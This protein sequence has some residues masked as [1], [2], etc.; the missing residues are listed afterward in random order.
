MTASAA[1]AIPPTVARLQPLGD[2]DRQWL[3]QLVHRECGIVTAPDKSYLLQSRLAAVAASLAVP[4]ITDLLATLRTEQHI[5]RRGPR[6]ATLAVCDA[7]TTNET[8][9]FRDGHPFDALATRVLPELAA[10]RQR[11]QG[12]A[13]A[14]RPEP[15]RIWSAACATG[16]E[17]YSL[18]M[19]AALAAPHLGGVPVEI[20]ATDYS[21]RALARAREGLYSEFEVRRGLAPHHLARWFVPEPG[22]LRVA[23][24]L[25]CAVR[26]Q[27]QNL[28]ESFVGLGSFAVVLCRNGL[29]YF[30]APTRARVLEAIADT[31]RP[32]ALLFLGGTESTLGTCARFRRADLATSI[33]FERIDG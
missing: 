13:G 4:S 33:A 29:L 28:L 25:R 10:R 23:P 17:P 8:L 1:R 6:P 15:I 22:G 20:V 26:F 3:A 14:A 12:T 16:Q 30:D 5:G 18:A 9:F 21:E 7:L 31:M 19:V 11:A 24:A 32:G 2:A 27:R